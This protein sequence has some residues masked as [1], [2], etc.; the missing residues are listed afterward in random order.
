MLPVASH[1]EIREG[2]RS[3]ARHREGLYC[4]DDQ[5]ALYCRDDLVAVYC[6]DDR[7]GRGCTAGMT[8]WRCT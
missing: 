4:R 2:V 8:W 7:V 1:A 6:R 3:N 5:V